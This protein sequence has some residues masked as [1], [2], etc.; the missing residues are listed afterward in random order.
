MA[1]QNNGCGIGCGGMLALLALG[2]A[3]AY[4]HFFLIAAVLVAAIAAVVY[5]ALLHN[6][7]QLWLVMQQVERSQL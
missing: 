6:Q 7:Q 5:T 2:F 1:Q 4:W 3:L